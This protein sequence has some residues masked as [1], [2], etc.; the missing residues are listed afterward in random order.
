MTEANRR[1]AL[2]IRPDGAGA[3]IS[4]YSSGLA[5]L[6]EPDYVVED[7]EARHFEPP[8]ANRVLMRRKPPRR[9]VRTDFDLVHITDVY[10]SPQA[11]RFDGARVV[12]VHDLMPREFRRVRSRRA[13]MFAI[14]FERSLRTLRSVDWW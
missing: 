14:V 9:A 7:S 6:L 13:L 4:R 8:K 10:M 5:A 12:T 11:R 3:A 2:L 1:R